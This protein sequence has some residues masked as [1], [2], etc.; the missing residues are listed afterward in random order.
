LWLTRIYI[1]RLG[2]QVQLDSTPNQG[3]TVSI[4][5]PAVQERSS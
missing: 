5:L 4:R 2:G 1:S 3:T